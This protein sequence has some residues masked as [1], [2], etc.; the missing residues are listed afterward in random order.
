MQE[1]LQ[2]IENTK[3]DAMPPLDA[4]PDVKS[5]FKAGEKQ[6]SSKVVP[7]ND[8]ART[9]TQIMT[10]NDARD[11]AAESAWSVEKL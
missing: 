2:L 1:D 9:Q 3:P 4:T 11:Q 6:K 10:E 7:V 5:G 8:S